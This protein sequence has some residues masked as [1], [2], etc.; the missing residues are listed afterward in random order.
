MR[1]YKIIGPGALLGVLAGFPSV[2]AG[3]EQS[4]APT[5]TTLEEVV[6]TGTSIRGAAPVGSNLITVGR[7]EIEASGAQT[8]AQ[9]LRSVPA[10]TGFGSSRAGAGGQGGGGGG[11]FVLFD[12]RGSHTPTIQGLGASARNGTVILIY[13]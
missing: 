8:L 1:D 5:Q 4:T 6:V 11:G 13:G 12:G 2:S 9:V 10:V 7:A 3:Q